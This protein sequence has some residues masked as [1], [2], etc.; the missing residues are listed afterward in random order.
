MAASRPSTEAPSFALRGVG[1]HF[2]GIYACRHIDLEFR[3]GEVLAIL[4]ENG[5][6]RAPP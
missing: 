6:G 1:K 2:G 5:A 4:G 3:A